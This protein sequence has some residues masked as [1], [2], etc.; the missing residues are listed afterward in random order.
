VFEALKPGGRIVVV[1]AVPVRTR[2]RPRTEQFK[3]HVLAP[4]HG[5]SD[6]RQAG[7]T[8]IEWRDGFI[9][10]PDEERAWWMIRAER[11]RGP[12]PQE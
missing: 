3:N 9:D 6:L 11:P 7:F 12:R 2:G 8:G 1:D 5:E 10:N 4:E